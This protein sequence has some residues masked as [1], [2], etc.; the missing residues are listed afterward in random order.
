AYCVGYSGYAQY[1]G[2]FEDAQP[3]LCSNWARIK[4]DSRLSLEDAL[5]AMRAAW[6]RMA[7]EHSRRTGMPADVR[8]IRRQLMMNSAR[9]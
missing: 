5:P 1:G 2:A 8:L 6:D 4:G 7:G 3:W 9:G